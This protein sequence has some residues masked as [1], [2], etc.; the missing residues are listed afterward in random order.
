MDDMPWQGT[1]PSVNG[2]LVTRSEEKHFFRA[3]LQLS[4][5]GHREDTALKQGLLGEH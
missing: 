2:E 4:I 1:R 3:P 5:G